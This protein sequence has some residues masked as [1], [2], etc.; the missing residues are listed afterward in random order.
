MSPADF[1]DG[2]GYASPGQGGQRM[3]EE[4]GSLVS[5]ISQGTTQ[6]G[7]PYYSRR[8]SLNNHEVA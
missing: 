2:Q 1:A 5:M 4:G 3:A 7:S 8:P 6:G